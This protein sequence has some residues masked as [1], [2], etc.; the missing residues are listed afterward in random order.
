[1]QAVTKRPLLVGLTDNT[2]HQ[3]IQAKHKTCRETNV[4]DYNHTNSNNNVV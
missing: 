3:V 2:A 4:K 1:M